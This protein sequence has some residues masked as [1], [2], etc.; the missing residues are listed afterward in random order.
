MKQVS[1]PICLDTWKVYQERITPESDTCWTS[2]C[3]CQIEELS[4]YKDRIDR[5]ARLDAGMILKEQD[6]SGKEV[7]IANK[8]RWKKYLSIRSELDK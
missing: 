6:I 2:D 5:Q 7:W 4:E 1:C 8:S 3:E